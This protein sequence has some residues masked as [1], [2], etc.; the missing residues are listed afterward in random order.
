MKSTSASAGVVSFAAARGAV[1]ELAASL[2]ARERE[3]VPLPQALGRVLAEEV[4][5]DRDQPP[6]PRATRDGYAVRSADTG[7]SASLRV[8]G[9]LRAGAD[10]TRV[11]IAAGEA[12]EIM[13]GAAVPFGADAVIMVEHTRRE[14]ERVFCERAV[15]NRENVVLAGAEAKAGA[16]LLSAGTRL[17]APEIALLAALGRAEVPVFHRPRVAVLATGDELVEL[18]TI[19]TPFQIRNSNSHSLA[20]QVT[21]AGGVPVRLPVAPD[22]AAALHRALEEGLA[23]ELLLLSGGV[24]AGKYDLVEPALTAFDAHFLFTGALIQ[25]GRPIVCGT[26][27][28]GEGSVPFF[29][30]PGN[31]L[32]T[33]VCFELFVRPV[34]DALRGAA[35]APLRF[36][37][38]PLAAEVRVK[39]GL[40][41]FLPAALRGE[42]E[43][44]AVEL[45]RWQG[46]GDL[47]S[48]TRSDCYIVVPP[49]RESLAAGEMVSV[50]LP[51]R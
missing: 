26:A 41:R 27:V 21:A 13:T 33:M 15:G 2:A 17:R 20:A 37:R 28:R 24:S 1:E 4:A 34:L 35:P 25:P 46:S 7:P 44:T 51:E 14:G 43:G 18:D 22:E 42:L 10:A 47:A 36:L 11:R 9:E 50:L 19:P 32:S 5:A 48:A 12:V 39:T 3:R 29:G 16:V 38:A 30:L 8:T 40:T 49:D 45:V 6:F 31:P 23:A